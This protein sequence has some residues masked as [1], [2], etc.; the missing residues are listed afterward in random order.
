MID[1]GTH[2]APN[3]MDLSTSDVE[4][5]IAFYGTL[6]GWSIARRDTPLGMYAI[7]AVGELEIAGMMQHVPAPGMPPLWTVFLRVEDVDAT[8]VAVHA[9]GGSVLQPAF[10]LPDA[11]IAVVADP[12]GGMFGIIS[13]PRPEGVYLDQGPGTVAWVELLTRDPRAA[14]P[15]Y[16][17]V[18]GW[19]T[20]ESEADS[21]MGY[22][23]FLLDDDPVAGLMLM[24]AEI[25]AE[26]P[27]YWSV[28]FAVEDLEAGVARTTE[29]GGSVIAPPMAAGDER[30]VVLEDPQGAVFGL[31]EH[32]ATG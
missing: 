31:L 13:G 8:A 21:E 11:R 4:A 30:F 16:A 17:E 2:G 3:W 28:Y 20:Q 24:P 29:L 22:T 9:A 23:M 6:F 7:G 10:D 12:T 32:P 15:F 26:V 25:P 1:A 18:F 27:A 19:K 14:E 5:A